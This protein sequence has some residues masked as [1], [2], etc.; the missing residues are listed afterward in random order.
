MK[1]FASHLGDFQERCGA[2]AAQSD[3]EAPKACRDCDGLGSIPAARME[4]LVDT[5]KMSPPRGPGWRGYPW[6]CP[7]KRP[8]GGRRAGRFGGIDAELDAKP[9]CK[10][11]KAAYK[12]AERVRVAVLEKGTPHSLLLYGA[13]GTGKSTVLSA[14]ASSLADRRTVGWQNW[15]EIPGLLEKARA[16]NWMGN[17]QVIDPLIKWD[18]L[19]IDGA[20]CALPSLAQVVGGRYSY[21]RP[22]F[23]NTCLT[24]TDL[25]A[26]PLMLG[27]I[28][29]AYSTIA[30]DWPS[31]TKAC[32]VKAKANVRGAY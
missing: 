1:G 5:G 20:N 7:C 15:T 24:M 2:R 28:R 21:R 4:W 31:F 18:V 16:G 12:A 19:V 17:A 13:P 6:A 25:K 3:D 22:T 14:L 27:Q 30:C 8:G 9:Y 32:A 26:N 29:E 10:E 23:I 11:Q